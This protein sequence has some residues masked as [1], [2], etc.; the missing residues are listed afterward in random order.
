MTEPEIERAAE[1]LAAAEDV[2]GFT[3]AGVSTESGIPDFRSEG[4][5]WDRYDPSDFTIQALHRDPVAYWERRLE[6]RENREFD[7]GEIEPNPAHHAY[8]DLERAGKLDALV[9]QNVDGLH[10]AA[11]SE[12][13]LEL[14]GT[15]TAAKC[16]GC[17]RRLPTDVLE[18][19]LAENDLP[20]RCDDCDGLLKRA[21]V[22]FGEALPRD[23]L[24]EARRSVERCDALLVAGS[25][26]TVEPAASMPRVALQHG[27]DLVVVNL[28]E[29][30]VDDRADVVIRG[31]AGETLPPVV[32]RALEGT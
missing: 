7:W 17:E 19:K 8:A 12:R 10:Q 16:L 1:V 28:D 32:E 31:K 29:T 4:G 20:P 18:R 25:S 3:G 30:S 22:S 26:L 5:L 27:A 6:M 13:V 15:R 2:V 11:G 9:T 21:T 24:Q 23:T 14:H